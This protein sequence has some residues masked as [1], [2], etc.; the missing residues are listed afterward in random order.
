MRHG[1]KVNHLG[2]KTAHRK[3]M[4]ANMSTSLILHK[5]IT[6]T[7]AKA[8]ELRKFVE[9]LITKCKEDNTHNRRTVFAMLQNK[10]AIKELF[11]AVRPKVMDRPGGYLRILKIGNRLG[12][13]AEM[14]IIELV[15]FNELAPGKAA[16]AAKKSTRRRQKSK[17]AETEVIAPVAE[18]V[19]P[20]VVEE[21]TNT[22]EEVVTPVEETV[23]PVAEEVTEV[24]ADAV[25]GD[26]EEKKEE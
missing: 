2:R 1:N 20:E 18:V 25:E 9:P 6:T 10:Y 16:T 11:G 14:A 13:N 3:S 24:V 17:T 8:K 21:V 5:R 23:A 12:D 26:A 19:T 7:V 15:D 22:V 4:L